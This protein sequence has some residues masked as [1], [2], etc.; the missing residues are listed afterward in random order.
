MSESHVT[1]FSDCTLNQ[2]CGL[3]RANL[4]LWLRLATCCSLFLQGKL[5]VRQQDEEILDLKGLNWKCFIL[6][7]PQ[8]TQENG[9]DTLNPFGQLTRFRGNIYSMHINFSLMEFEPKRW[10]Y[11]W[12]FNMQPLLLPLLLVLSCIFKIL[13]SP[14]LS[15]TYSRQTLS[16]LLS[17][18]KLCIFAWQGYFRVCKLCFTEV[19][20]C[21]PILNQ[22]KWTHKLQSLNSAQLLRLILLCGKGQ[23]AVDQVP[24]TQIIQLPFYESF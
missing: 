20:I 16:W 23:P 22:V 19:I 11:L 17:L 9:F 12:I 6:T 21:H 5:L 14:P 13:F 7:L 4:K 18:I 1:P 2:I 3:C 15:Q 24:A 10:G 8:C